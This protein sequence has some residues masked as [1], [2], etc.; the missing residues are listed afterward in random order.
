[1]RNFLASFDKDR[2]IEEDLTFE[3]KVILCLPGPSKAKIVVPYN[4]ELLLLLAPT[5]EVLSRSGCCLPY[6]LKG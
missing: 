1:M 4:V 3:M 6:V 5:C 2:W